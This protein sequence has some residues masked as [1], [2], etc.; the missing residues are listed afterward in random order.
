MIYELNTTN[1]KTI[2]SVLLILIS[3]TID[4]ARASQPTLET[5]LPSDDLIENSTIIGTG[6][7]KVQTKTMDQSVIAAIISGNILVSSAVITN[8]PL[9][10]SIPFNRKIYN[11]TFVSDSK[12]DGLS[13]YEMDG[14]QV[15]VF[16]SATQKG[17]VLLSARPAALWSEESINELKVISENKGVPPEKYGKL[18]VPAQPIVAAYFLRE[19]LVSNATHSIKIGLMKQALES[20]NPQLSDFAS[21]YAWVLM[22]LHLDGASKGVLLD[23]ILKDLANTAGDISSKLTDFKRLGLVELDRNSTWRDDAI[24]TLSALRKHPLSDQERRQIDDLLQA[25]S[26]IGS[27]I[28][29]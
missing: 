3:F 9:P 19:S 6:T 18:I 16:A 7:K 22:K 12:W 20:G 25:V 26:N 24:E 13:G 2:S 28:G 8:L 10:A 27:N 11:T 15:L 23:L 17:V 29:E 14:V 5:L 1:M 21:H 4:M